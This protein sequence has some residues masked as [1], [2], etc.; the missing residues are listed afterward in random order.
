MGTIGVGDTWYTHRDEPNLAYPL[1]EHARNWD[2]G[3]ITSMQE[4]SM[5]VTVEQSPAVA[6]VSEASRN[7]TVGGGRS[8]IKKKDHA[9]VYPALENQ[10][11]PQVTPSPAKLPP[12]SHVVQGVT[13]GST[14]GGRPR[15][16]DGE[17]IQNVPRRPSRR[18]SISTLD[19]GPGSGSKRGISANRVVEVKVTAQHVNSDELLKSA[20]NNLRCIDWEN[21]SEQLMSSSTSV[22]LPHSEQ[23]SKKNS[24]N[25]DADMQ[26]TSGDGSKA[27]P[28]TNYDL[29]RPVLPGEQIDFF[30]SHSWHD[31][32]RD[33]WRGNMAHIQQAS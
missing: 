30:M 21:I 29:S 10:A 17:T 11:S 18:L 31:G 32:K 25:F 7:N 22:A 6:V 19:F 2:R 14:L 23:V 15:G 3:I 9:K 33:T 8:L 27:N 13:D 26:P 1:G 20:W 5:Q 24:A 12:P 28:L 4:G 16:A